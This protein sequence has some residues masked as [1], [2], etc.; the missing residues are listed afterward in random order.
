MQ[1]NIQGVGLDV[2]ERVR[3]YVEYRMFAAAS[4]F[5][6][7][8]AR[9]S[10]RLNV[11]L[12]PGGL[13]ARARYRCVATMDLGPARSVRVSASSDLLHA[14]VDRAAERLS[15]SAARRLAAATTG[16][17][18]SRSPQVALRGPDGETGWESRS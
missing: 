18:R 1:I 5:D 13:S 3:A 11:R 10:V 8:D 16:A 14:A 2:S 7:S 4:R 15:R 12:E 9:L 6:G 17:E